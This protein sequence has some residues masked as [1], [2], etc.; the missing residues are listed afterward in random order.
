MKNNF[1]LAITQLAA[2]RNLPKELV[3]KAVES[4]LGS[5]Y[6]KD[7]SIGKYDIAVSI[8]PTNGEI[9][10]YAQKVVTEKPA[11]MWHEI[12]LADARKIQKDVQLGETIKVEIHPPDAGRIGVQ[13]AKQV[14][15][16][17]LREAEREFIFGTF[18]HREGEIIAGI[19]QQVDHRHAIVDLG[20]ADGVLPIAEQVRTEHYR[21][22]QRLKVY[23]LEVS[24]T[25]KGPR[26]LL[27]RTHPNL[28]R[29]LFELEVPEI[30]NGLVE[31]KAVARE[32]GSRTKIAVAAKQEE[33]D[34]VG[35]CIGLRGIRIQSIINEL[36]GEKVDVI[37]WDQDP[38]VFVA[39]ALSPA[40]TLAV[41]I[42]QSQ[43][44]AI[45]IVPDGQLSLAIGREGQNARLAAR[46]TNWKIDIKSASSV[47]PEKIEVP[48]AAE[49]AAIEKAAEL[50]A[51][52]PEAEVLA[53]PEVA[54]ESAEEIIP[55]ETVIEKRPPLPE[56][57][58]IRFAE[59]I[60]PKTARTGD[61]T[62]KSKKKFT[63][64]KPKGTKKAKLVKLIED[65][66]F[67]DA[68]TDE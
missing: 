52:V 49:I 14:V 60:L 51:V 21:P 50:A 33:I 59:D 27:S 47:A 9:R 65:D 3:F 39:N 8:L 28:V 12:S 15:M 6:R 68:F 64:E 31:L 10:V 19:V 62:E 18:A 1:L 41:T 43:M 2:E 40:Q 34:P 4:A 30:S 26:L 63:D 17:R 35:S 42:D 53:E 16:Q 55:V 7:E 37:K 58:Q 38:K 56:G 29:R 46:L 44:S 66:G 32:P 23:L 57:P 5:T 61:K 54:E 24:Q 67:E 11:D 45:A 22:G 20:K 13:T 36:Q 48:I 25:T